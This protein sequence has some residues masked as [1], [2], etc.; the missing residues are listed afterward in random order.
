[1]ALHQEGA[2]T[3]HTPC[4]RYATARLAVAQES[5]GATER[6]AVRNITLSVKLAARFLTL[7]VANLALKVALLRLR[8]PQKELM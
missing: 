2:H 3:R 7:R 5:K 1:M 6:N 8:V 4:I